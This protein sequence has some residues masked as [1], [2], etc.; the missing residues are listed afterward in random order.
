M[1]L[2]KDTG[3]KILL[4][5]GSVVFALVVCE[6]AARFAVVHLA[7]DWQFL[8]YAS[9]GQLEARFGRSDPEI[10]NPPYLA[11]YSLHPY[12]GY[13][14]TPNYR[15][16]KNRH[17]SLGFRGDEILIPKPEGEFR[18]ACLGGSTTYSITVD[19]WHLAYPALLEQELQVAGYRSIRVINAGAA[20]WTSFE[21]LANLTGRVLDLDPDLII[22]YHGINDIHTRLVWPPE[23]YR[24]DNTGSVAP[25]A[26]TQHEPAW[27]ESSTIV[28]GL[29]IRAGKILPPSSFQRTISMHASTWY[30]DLFQKQWM[31]GT[32]PDGIFRDV[33][34]SRMLA[35][36]PPTYFRRNLRD[37]VA[38]AE[39][40]DASVVLA[41][42]A[43]SPLFEQ[44]PR[45]ASAEYIHA[46]DEMNQVVR[47]VADE[48]G[49]RLFDF[50][51][52]FPIAEEY[53][54]DGRHLTEE[55]QRLKAHLFEE[56][57][58]ESGLLP[59]SIH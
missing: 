7:D 2:K 27:Y 42:F 38:V 48:T 53:Y 26:A 34:V 52:Q 23:S 55:G 14:P 22:V 28:R 41:T 45:V 40:N 21:S 54:T 9:A 20:G 19:D 17:N 11:A 6:L 43:F 37:I 36:N 16:G 44:Y 18:I 5:V 56:F 32:Y 58:V 59:G 51:S 25:V 47:E 4:A 24:G 1:A 46:Y 15:H 30:A 33:S 13:A 50:A 31:D 57:L 35:T 8:R 49:A 39:A 10:T 29:L 12:L 3:R